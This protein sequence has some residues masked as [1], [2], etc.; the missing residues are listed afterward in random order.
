M[1]RMI[2][3]TDLMIIIATYDEQLTNSKFGETFNQN[4]NTCRKLSWTHFANVVSGRSW[5]CWEPQY[6]CCLCCNSSWNTSGSCIEYYGRKN[7]PKCKIN[8]SVRES[9]WT[10]GCYFERNL[11]LNINTPKCKIKK[12]VRESSWTNGCYFERNLKLNIEWTW[13]TMVNSRA[14]LLCLFW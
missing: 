13:M 12:S 14:R 11:K 4:K 6:W 8:K 9:S 10:N 1:K 7:T 3:Y 2:I 5:R